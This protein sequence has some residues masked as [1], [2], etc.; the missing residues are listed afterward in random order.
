VNAIPSDPCDFAPALG[1]KYPAITQRRRR[2]W[3]RVV[4]FLAVP[5][6]V[7]RIIYITNAIERQ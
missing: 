6:A 2:N 7:R 1:E 4:P 5:A 3:E